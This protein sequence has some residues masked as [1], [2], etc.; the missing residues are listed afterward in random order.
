[1]RKRKQ[2]TVYVDADVYDELKKIADNSDVLSLGMIIRMALKRELQLL[3]EKKTD[4][5]YEMR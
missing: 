3:K 2:V 4:Y 5:L 1:M